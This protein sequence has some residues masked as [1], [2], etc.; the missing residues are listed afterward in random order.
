MQ[1]AK[2][3]TLVVLVSLA[4]GMLFRTLPVA[5]PDG[6]VRLRWTGDNGAATSVRSFGARGVGVYGVL[7]LPRFRRVIIYLI[8]P[9][10]RSG[11]P[12]LCHSPA[13]V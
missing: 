4:L 1:K 5:D 13:V 6:L 8:D 2:G 12:F 3:W 9:P 7:L 10:A 11:L